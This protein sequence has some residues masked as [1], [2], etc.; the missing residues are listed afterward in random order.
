M[1]IIMN[2]SEQYPQAFPHPACL[3]LGTGKKVTNIHVV[4]GY[5]N[6]FVYIITVYEPDIN[7]WENGYTIRKE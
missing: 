2:C 5:D 1:D 3:I 4:L 7:E 6:S